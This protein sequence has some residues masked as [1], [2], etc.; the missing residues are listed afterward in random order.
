MPDVDSWTEQSSLGCSSILFLSPLIRSSMGEFGPA[1]LTLNKR[2]LSSIPEFMKILANGFHYLKSSFSPQFNLG[3]TLK[4]AQ[5]RTKSDQNRTKTGSVAPLLVG[6]LS[7]I[8]CVLGD[9]LLSWSAKRQHT[10]S[11]SSVEA[12]YR[13]IANVVAE[14]AWLR[15]LLRDNVSAVYMFANPVQHQRTKH[16]EIN[17]HFVRDMFKASHVRVLHVPSR[18]QYAD[19][20]IKGLPSALFEDFRSSLSVRPPPAQTVGAY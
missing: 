14:T 11:R 2:F 20:F 7:V 16:I 10:I 1:H 6:E 8:V 3:I 13:G 12:E 19:I 18:F 9:N 17:I 4:K 5:K 15:N